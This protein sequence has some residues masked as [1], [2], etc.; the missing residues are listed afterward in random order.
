[1]EAAS[2]FHQI[3]GHLVL[4]AVVVMA[5]SV[6]FSLS[7]GGIL[8]LI[9]SL[10]N[11]AYLVALRQVLLKRKPSDISRRRNL[12]VPVLTACWLILLFAAWLGVEPVVEEMLTLR[13]VSREIKIQ[14]WRDTLGIIQDYPVVGTGMGTFQYIYPAYQSF[15]ADVTFTHTENDYLQLL[16]EGGAVGFALMAG[17]IALVGAAMMRGM[18]RPPLSTNSRRPDNST[19]VLGC[20]AALLSMLVHSF[21][22][23]NLHIPANAL[24]FTAVLAMGWGL[25]TLN[26]RESHAR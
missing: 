11:I 20:F 7:R 22:D 10:L 4:F 26:F 25:S 14:V 8:T 13:D 24:L 9:L 18:I 2:G 23:F 21:F 3:T 19:I 12:L 6:L 5:V 16:S 15:P 17:I 1:M